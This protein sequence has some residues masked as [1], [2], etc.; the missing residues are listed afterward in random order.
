M[1]T[2]P[3]AWLVLA[4]TLT[5]APLASGQDRVV[6]SLMCGANQGFNVAGIYYGTMP[7]SNPASRRAGFIKILK[8]KEIHALRFPGGTLA[9][10]YLPDNNQGMGRVPI[11]LS[12]SLPEP[13]KNDY[14]SPWQFFDFCKEAG[15]EAIYQLNTLLYAEGEKVYLLADA[16]KGGLFGKDDLWGGPGLV[17]IP[18]KRDAAAKAVTSFAATTRQ[19]GFKVTHWELDN[20]E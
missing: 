20:G 11:L 7:A 2:S 9:N 19:R 5:L 8:D 1:R 10:V 16:G 13:G 12:A 18:E 15:I 6:S 3:L 4:G 17:L 14:V